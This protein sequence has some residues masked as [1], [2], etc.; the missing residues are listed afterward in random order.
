MRKCIFPILSVLFVVVF[1]SNCGEYDLPKDDTKPDYTG[2]V[3]GM[4]E[5]GTAKSIG[6]HNLG[7]GETIVIGSAG[8]DVGL[9][10]MGITQVLESSSSISI[11]A[12][13]IIGHS[14]GEL[15]NP[16]SPLISI[17]ISNES[18]EFE[19]LYKISIP[20]E[21][22]P[23]EDEFMM[24]FYYDS[25]TGELEGI[26]T[27][28]YQSNELTIATTHFSG[29][30]ITKAKLALLPDKI[31][32]GFK[33][34]IDG[35]PYTNY[36]T[37]Y[38]PGGI[39]AGMSITAMYVY[40]QH[41]GNLYSLADNDQFPGSPSPNFWQDDAQG[42]IFGNYGQNYYGSIFDVWHSELWLKGL[43]D[44]ITYR[45]FA[46]SMSITGEPQYIRIDSNSGGAHAMVA[47]AID[48]HQIFV[49]DPNYPA[50]EDRIV[51][52]KGRT[53]GDF[54]PYYSGDNAEDIENGKGKSYDLIT[55]ASK[56][57]LVPNE[58]I[59]DAYQKYL[60]HTL[61]KNDY[62]V[63]SL[64][65]VLEDKD[66]KIIARSTNPK[67]VCAEKEVKLKFSRGTLNSNF[68]LTAIFYNSSFE[69]IEGMVT[70]NENEETMIGVYV[71]GKNGTKWDWIGFKWFSV[72][73][74]KQIHSIDIMV[75]PDEV[76]TLYTLNGNTRNMTYDYLK[77]Y[78][79]VVNED[80]EINGNTISIS[81]D[82]TDDDSHTNTNI[83]ITF[84]D[85]VNP[86]NIVGFYMKRILTY[87]NGQI[88][89]SSV[90][91]ENMPFTVSD[92]GGYGVTYSYDYKGDISQ[93]LT[94][95]KWKAES[96]NH[97]D[98]AVSYSSQGTVSIILEY[99]HL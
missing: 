25:N 27:V 82:T 50:Q 67:M 32:T 17:H 22:E 72:E 88:V 21:D 77:I 34:Q 59:S 10:E 57:A 6:N 19:T 16:I 68:E 73:Y 26:P 81:Y 55:Y 47:Y 61:H 39:C 24:A 53:S 75:K 44:A 20:I 3:E 85:I 15:I 43:D 56:S 78:G 95:F 80:G 31:F 2:P 40:G 89:T 58:G 4:L 63:E 70:L 54:D 36:G 98:E 92:W 14:Y 79:E 30:F 52:F 41:G 29:F 74:S 90:S 83:N 64:E 1:F 71:L 37:Y 66:E 7:E 69:R 84:D 46:Y 35:W 65:L 42:I 86:T 62:A 49:Y 76:T 48:E 12:A 93:Y 96:A 97:T 23:E 11:S 91:E 33:P 13:P 60:N 9:E 51:N 99:T 87:N 18:N 8:S 94:E 5:I 45:C 28:A 38:N